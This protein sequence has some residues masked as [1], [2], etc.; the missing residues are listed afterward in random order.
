M[1]DRAGI[2]EMIEHGA[3]GWI[4][5]GDAETGTQEAVAELTANVDR[6][7]ALAKAAKELAASR[8]W[9]VVAAETLR[10]YEQAGMQ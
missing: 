3:S 4:V 7:V 9:E 2:C 1:T 10:V 5:K 6:R 8:T